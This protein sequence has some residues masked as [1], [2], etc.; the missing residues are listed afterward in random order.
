MTRIFVCL[1]FLALAACAGPSDPPLPVVH[2]SDPII[3]LVPDHLE[4]GQLPK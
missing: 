4:Y 3:Q 2:E 1:L